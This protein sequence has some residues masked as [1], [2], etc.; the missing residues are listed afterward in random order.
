M[1]FGLLCLAGR[2]LDL[3]TRGPE[4]W[5]LVDPRSRGPKWGQ[6]GDLTA[7][8]YY[9][10]ARRYIVVKTISRPGKGP[11][12]DESDTDPTRVES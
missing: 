10:R 5:K 11:S 7:D 4:L 1:P 6:M 3:H 2:R 8:P 12:V 9:A